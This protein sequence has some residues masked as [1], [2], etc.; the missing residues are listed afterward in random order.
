MIIGLAAL[1]NYSMYCIAGI[2]P[3]NYELLPILTF[4]TVYYIIKDYNRGSV[5]MQDDRKL[6]TVEDCRT[7][8]KRPFNMDEGSTW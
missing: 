2:F 1:S 5:D 7:R 6:Q 8:H 3:W 4:I